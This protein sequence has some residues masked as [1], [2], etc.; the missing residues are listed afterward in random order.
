MDKAFKRTVVITGA[1]AGIGLATAKRIAGRGHKVII[2]CRNPAKAHEAISEI[3]REIDDADLAF[4]PLDLSSFGSVH[5]FVTGLLRDHASIDVL[6][7][8]AGVYPMEQSF[9]CEGF[10]QQIGVNY[11]GH[12]LLTH[13]LLPSLVRSDDARIIHLSSIM[14]NLGRI[15]C[16]TF[17]GRR[18]YSG[19][20]AYAQSKL[21]NLMFSNEL[22]LRLPAHVTSNAL[23]PGA[24]D[25]EIYRDMPSW[26]YRLI[27]PFLISPERAGD[28]IAD[29]ADSPKWRGRSG[30]FKA[31]HGPLP[32]SRKSRSVED[33]RRLY[34]QS[35]KLTGCT[36]IDQSAANCIEQPAVATQ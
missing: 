35:C 7:N 8:N 28:F 22:A 29:M 18:K 34:E 14:H 36:G 4:Y 27:R 33:N 12:F 20:S 5:T 1:N 25:S 24:V 11:L 17:R 26:L 2:A 6:I 21:A 16:D 31:A 19:R 13:L 3:G 15:N 23:H 9:T 32:V 30:E 10:E